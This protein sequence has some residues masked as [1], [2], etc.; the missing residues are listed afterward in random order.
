MSTLIVKIYYLEDCSYNWRIYEN[1]HVSN[2]RLL[3][4]LDSHGSTNPLGMFTL[5]FK[6]TADVLAPHHAVVFRRLLLLGSFPVLW[7]EANVAKIPMGSSSVA[8]YRPISLIPMY[9]FQGIWSSGIGGYG[10]VYSKTHRHLPKWDSRCYK[11]PES[12]SKQG[13]CVV[14]PV[15]NKIECE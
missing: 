11:V 6:T 7:S 8:N 14:L 12:W 10:A 2:R 1:I 3:L 15:G 13:L 9:I 4:D 5:F